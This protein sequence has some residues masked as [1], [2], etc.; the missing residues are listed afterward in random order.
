MKENI[1]NNIINLKKKIIRKIISKIH[2]DE[3]DI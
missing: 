2:I 3:K 1:E